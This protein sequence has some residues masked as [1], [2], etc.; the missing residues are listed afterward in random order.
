MFVVHAQV[1]VVQ[2]DRVA[3]AGGVLARLL[4]L[5][6]RGRGRGVEG[7]HRIADN[8]GALHVHRPPVARLHEQRVGVPLFRAVVRAV[9]AV[10]V[11]SVVA[12]DRRSAAACTGR[13]K[14][15]KRELTENQKKKPTTT[16]SSR[17]YDRATPSSRSVV[18]SPRGIP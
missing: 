1:Q 5:V 10:D 6:A 18:G 17:H 12:G 16:R 4:L 8:G 11:V 14:K 9:A 3:V 2:F 15:N 7:E 13:G